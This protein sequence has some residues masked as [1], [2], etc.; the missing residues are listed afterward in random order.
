MRSLYEP[1]CDALARRLLITLPPWIYVEKKKDNW[2][3]ALG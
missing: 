2:Q 3:A 1:Y